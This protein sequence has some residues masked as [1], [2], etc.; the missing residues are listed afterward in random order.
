M[1]VSSFTF[2]Y[3]YKRIAIPWPSIIMNRRLPSKKSSFLP[4]MTSW[5]ILLLLISERSAAAFQQQGVSGGPTSIQL[6][7][8]RTKSFQN[9][10]TWY[11]SAASSSSSSPRNK[12]QVLNSEKQ[13]NSDSLSFETDEDLK[14]EIKNEGL[15]R[16]AELSLQDYQWRS[17]KF[18]TDE[19]DRQVE[20]SLARMMGEE[21]AYVRP[22]DASEEKIGPLVSLWFFV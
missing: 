15:L 10:N 22:M 6:G 16:L 7:T 5:T 19:A 8:R 17:S 2:D 20:E 3:Q 18:K 13:D 1:F 14:R 4:F 21:A 12:L 9:G 11:H